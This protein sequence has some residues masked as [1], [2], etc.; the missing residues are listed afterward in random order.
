MT[1]VSS[2]KYQE[3]AIFGMILV[4]T[5][6]LTSLILESKSYALSIQLISSCLFLLLVY[7]GGVFNSSLLVT[8]FLVFH[9]MANGVFLTIVM[10][11]KRLA[12]GGIFGKTLKQD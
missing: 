4:L 5:V 6:L 12:T 7:V 11:V 3:T 8:Q 1:S 2:L 9:A 10:T